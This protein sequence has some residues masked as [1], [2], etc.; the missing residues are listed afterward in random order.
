MAYYL[1]GDN[2]KISANSTTEITIDKGY[3]PDISMTVPKDATGLIEPEL[4]RK[5]YE[6]YVQGE[7]ISRKSTSQN[8][9]IY[10]SRSN[11]SGVTLGSS[12]NIIPV[13]SGGFIAVIYDSQTVPIYGRRVLYYLNNIGE[14]IGYY[15]IRQNGTRF[16]DI[17]TLNS[18]E[19]DGRFYFSVMGVGAEGASLYNMSLDISGNNS[20]P[21]SQ[22]FKQEGDIIVLGQGINSADSTFTKMVI[23][24]VE[25]NVTFSKVNSVSD[26]VLDNSE[27]VSYAP[28]YNYDIDTKTFSK[29]PK[30]IQLYN[31]A[32]KKE[33]NLSSYPGFASKGPGNSVA[34]DRIEQL[35]NGNYL[36]TTRAYKYKTNTTTNE[37]VEVKGI[38]LYDKDLNFKKNLYISSVGNS[39]SGTI[40]TINYFPKMDDSNH[41]YFYGYS[42]IKEGNL[43]KVNTT[44]EGTLEKKLNYPAGTG[45]LISSQG[46]VGKYSYILSTKGDLEDLNIFG[47]TSQSIVSGDM[48]EDFS[49][50]NVSVMEF[51]EGDYTLNKIISLEDD[52]DTVY[53]VFGTIKSSSNELLGKFNQ[54]LPINSFISTNN[55]YNYFGTFKREDDYAPIIK[56]SSH[57]MVDLDQVVDETSR[58][59]QLLKDILVYDTVDSNKLFYG[60][61][62]LEN[63]IQKNINSFDP[64][65]NDYTQAIDWK[66]LGFEDNGKVGPNRVTYFVTDS[67][68]SSTTTS[69]IV[70]KINKKTVYDET[71]AKAA[72]YAENFTIKLKDVGKLTVDQLV[73]KDTTSS[74]GN[75][76]AWDLNTGDN[77]NAN[78]TVDATQL[79]TINATTKFGKFQLD[80]TLTKDGKPVL[81]TDGQPLTKSTWVYVMGDN[82]QQ[83]G[84]KGTTIFN[85][86]A[87]KLPWD[88]TSTMT[89]GALGTKVMTDGNV[90]AYDFETGEDITSKIVT[91]VTADLTDLKATEPTD[92]KNPP[93][94][95][96]PTQVIHYLIKRDTEEESATTTVGT[97]VTVYYRFESL[98]VSFVDVAF[99]QLYDVEKNELAP[100]S[101]TIADQIVGKP[102]V[103]I[104]T[105]TDVANKI[106]AIKA[107]G[108]EQ[109]KVFKADKKTEITT[110]TTPITYNNGDG[111]QVYIRF[112]GL[113]TLV[114][115]PETIDFNLQAVNPKKT[116]R[117]DNPSVT[118]D[119]VVS[120]TRAGTDN[121]WAL[122]VKLSEP[123][124]S[125]N[126]TGSKVTLPNALRY[127]SSG[128][129]EFTVTS[130]A[131]EITRENSGFGT[132]D[133]SSGW[134]STKEATGFKFETPPVYVARLGEYEG[135]IT[136]IISDTYEP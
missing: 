89:E 107:K 39:I 129:D 100:T 41:S 86:D 49:I 122:K 29:I 88:I 64:I 75:V 53:A 48:N 38:S 61:K 31:P 27:F 114:S 125:T 115:V 15:D 111:N 93:T 81:Q 18:Y 121:K 3:T 6:D 127:K 13:P 57:R 2:G 99:G 34:L 76:L 19:K 72:L 47:V 14:V 17:T 50:K 78:V 74:Y 25:L 69:S 5:I 33:G 42:S 105:N 59:E 83:V 128:K 113:L 85:S 32:Q 65:T 28:F 104:T 120:D 63:R 101:V 12:N 98:I 106:T 8:M 24:D 112:N 22:K 97:T 116:V 71:T 52:S 55:F 135:E 130:E 37:Y 21:D 123:I 70:N 1:N 82:S 118:G 73:G 66:T 26:A 117:V 132:Y 108:Y 11:F 7:S 119:L 90:V 87:I 109:E 30:T 136:Y 91:P 95:D 110:A 35:E 67:N 62:W 10:S 79:A 103:A 126:K 56:K 96:N 4:D 9:S 84:E 134:G 23:D 60:Q 43:F 45:L 44:G 68:I 131:Q 94:T 20:V 36:V 51:P 16:E 124:Q 133:V 58:D 54:H 40:E 46:D 77:Y 92:K 80:Y 102:S